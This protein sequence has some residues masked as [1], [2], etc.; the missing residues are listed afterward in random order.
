MSKAN[1]G[2]VSSES[3]WLVIDHPG[4]LLFEASPYRARAS[5]HPSC[6]RRGVAGL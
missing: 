3:T 6:I 1:G 4:A 5:R 2:V